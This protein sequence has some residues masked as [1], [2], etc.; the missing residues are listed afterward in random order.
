M[1]PTT[2]AK[3]TAIRTALEHDHPD[4][5][6]TSSNLLALLTSPAKAEREDGK[7]MV[8]DL[9]KTGTAILQAAQDAADLASFANRHEP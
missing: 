6:F 4:Q 1:T 2:V 3:A 9:V 8:R 5:H 7:R